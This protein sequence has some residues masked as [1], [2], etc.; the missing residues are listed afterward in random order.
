[1]HKLTILELDRILYYD[2]INLLKVKLSTDN[3]QMA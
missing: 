3:R 2:T 1:M